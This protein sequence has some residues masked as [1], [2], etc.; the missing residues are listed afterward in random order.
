[1][2]VCYSDSESVLSLLSDNAVIINFHICISIFG[3]KWLLPD[4]D[5]SSVPL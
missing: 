3:R 4:E 1:M 5:K 2:T